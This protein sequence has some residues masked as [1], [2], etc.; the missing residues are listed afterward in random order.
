MIYDNK[1][2][3]STF[4]LSLEAG[5]EL[6]PKT[7]LPEACRDEPPDGILVAPLDAA[8]WH[9]LNTGAGAG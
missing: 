6:E 5:P 2:G 1:T 8:D 3:K 4:A 9:S 7:S